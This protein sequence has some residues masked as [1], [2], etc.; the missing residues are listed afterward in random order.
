MPRNTS[1]SELRSEVLA[2]MRRYLGRHPELAFSTALDL[3]ALVVNRST[4]KA[5]LEWADRLAD[6]NKGTQGVEIVEP[7]AHSQRGGIQKRKRPTRK[8]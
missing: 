3:A 8:V 1:K 5:L 4:S 6:L 2:G 7:V